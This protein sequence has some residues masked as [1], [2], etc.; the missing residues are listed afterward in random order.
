[1]QKISEKIEKVVV[2]TGIGRQSEQ[3]HFE[4]K[5]LPEIMKEFAAITGQKP[6]E[7]KAKKSIAGFK[8]RMDEII[9]LKTTLRKKRMEDFIT[10]VVRIVLPRVKDFRGLELSNVDETGNLNIGL[11]SQLVFPEIDPNKS[12]VNFGVQITL[13]GRG[14]DRQKMIDFYRSIKVPLKRLES[15]S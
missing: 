9:G 12:K 6:S 8:L 15:K 1:M 3:A 4:D 11:K 13:V 2:N 14:R 10:R 7:R 5:I